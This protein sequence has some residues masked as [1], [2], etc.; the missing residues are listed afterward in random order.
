MCH[1]SYLHNDLIAGMASRAP[2]IFQWDSSEGPEGH[3]VGSL[4][5]LEQSAEPLESSL[6]PLVKLTAEAG[7]TSLAE[8]VWVWRRDENAAKDTIGSL[9]AIFLQT[10]VTPCFPKAPEACTL[11][12]KKLLKPRT[13]RFMDSFTWGFK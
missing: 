8:W 6:Q 10:Y 12:A 7:G 5:A 13:W 2:S 3:S 1:K 4:Q 9:I 11:R